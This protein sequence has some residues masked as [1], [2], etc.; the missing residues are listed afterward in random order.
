MFSS[1]RRR[2]EPDAALLAAQKA[3]KEQAESRQRLKQAYMSLWLAHEWQ[4]GQSWAQL[5]LSGMPWTLES[6]TSA[7]SEFCAVRYPVEVLQADTGFP[8]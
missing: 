2:S 1:K 4:K 5:D 3:A 7:L 6:A 8:H